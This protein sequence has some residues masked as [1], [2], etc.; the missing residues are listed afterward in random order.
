MLIPL[1]RRNSEGKGREVTQIQLGRK[2]RT[3]LSSE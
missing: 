1:E 2:G 3:Y